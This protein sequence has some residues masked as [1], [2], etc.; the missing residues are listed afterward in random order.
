VNSKEK[1]LF[2][3]TKKWQE[4]R[5][6]ILEKYE[7]TC[8]ICGIKK[9]KGLH[10]H[11]INEEKYGN[12]V[13]KDVVLLCSTHHK[14]IEYLLRRKVLDIDDFCKKLKEIYLK[15]KF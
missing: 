4:F 12:E 1:V 11:H 5:S 14:L 10:V 9:K 8:F 6:F 13:E 2:R 3:R 7:Y 15:S